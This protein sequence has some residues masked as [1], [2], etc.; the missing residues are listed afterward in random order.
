M[1]LLSSLPKLRLFLTLIT[2]SL[3]L[4]FA[5]TSTSVSSASSTT[6]PSQAPSEHD[7]NEHLTLR[8]LPGNSLLASFNFKSNGSLDHGDHMLLFPRSLKQVLTASWARELHVKFTLGR[9]NAEEY[10]V[11]PNLGRTAGGT[12]VEVWAWVEA[13]GEEEAFARWTTLTNALSGLFCASLNFIDATRTIRP[14]L[15]FQPTGHHSDATLSRLHLLHGSLPREPVC[16]E[17]LTPFL[18]LLP[19]KA[20]VGIS[21]LLDGHK[22]FDANWQSMS[23]DVRPV[24]D[25]NGGNCKLEM[26][27]AVDMV[28]DIERSLRRRDSPIPKPRPHDQLLCDETKPY[29]TEDASCFPLDN[30]FDLGWSLSEIF[31]RPI[32]GTCPFGVK[33]G[34]EAL[35]VCLEVPD[36]RP[37]FLSVGS[38]ER[39]FDPQLRCFLLPGEGYFDMILPKQRP[40]TLSPSTPPALFAERSF[41]G[42]GQERGGVQTILRNPSLTHSVEFVYLE[43][44]PWFMKPYL[45]TLSARLSGSPLAKNEAFIKETYYRPALDRKRGTHLEIR[46]SV[47]MNSTVLLT[48]DFEKAVLRYTEY[49]P[50]ANRGFDIAPA[51]IGILESEG[52]VGGVGGREGRKVVSYLRTTSLLLYLPTPDFSMPY[53]VIILTSTV[54][55]LAFGTVFNILVR[56]FVLKSEVPKLGG[57][58][59]GL[60]GK[61]KNLL[62]K[63][64]GKE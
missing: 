58:V 1:H 13:G 55:A 33:E 31:G 37:V 2:L 61:V 30:L 40:P 42:Y 46:M 57:R 48:Y 36:S 14:V 45:H 38:Q 4:P 8:P 23:I 51:I 49:P 20:K 59:S 62:L 47:P 19:C 43:S 7:Y 26:E 41:T 64:R 27:Q 29:L 3:C 5:S 54:I 60:V 35:R 44:L 22:L 9:W 15:S 18:K 11:Q 25:D 6:S 56:K 52:V 28:V 63:K 12:G 17:N 50:D 16:T 39:K 32:T 24:C 34:V 10:G 53:N 21:T